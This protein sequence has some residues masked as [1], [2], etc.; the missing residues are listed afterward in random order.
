MVLR[1]LVRVRQS[2]HSRIAERP[3]NKRH[4][5]RQVIAGES[6]GNGDGWHPDQKG[7]E[8]RR[9]PH[10]NEA[11]LTPVPKER[12]L[13][14][15]AL[16]HDGV[17]VQVSHHLH[18]ARHQ[19]VTRDKVFVVGGCVPSANTSHELV[20][21]LLEIRRCR[22]CFLVAERRVGAAAEVDVPTGRRV[23]S[24]RRPDLFSQVTKGQCIEFEVSGK[25]VRMDSKLLGSNIA[26]LS[27]Y[28]LVHETFRLFF[29]A[30]KKNRNN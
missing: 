16:M 4:P 18:Q 3:T 6:D 25:S 9:P 22:H 26:Y 27:R 21:D 11:R 24:W 29:N 19:L 20:D 8:V 30:V 12:W 10:G 2:D 5:R 23:R 17:E 14:L 1:L 13:M 15:S 7:V 28:E